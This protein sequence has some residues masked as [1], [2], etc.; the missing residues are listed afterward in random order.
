MKIIRNIIVA[1][2]LY[3]RIPMPIFTW[4]DEDME[5]S[6]AC[7]SLIGLV[8]GIVEFLAF[9]LIEIVNFNI[10]HEIPVFV[11]VIIYVLMPLII[12]GG[13]HVDGFMDFKDAINSYK[14]KDEKLAILKD[15]HIGAFS[16]ISLI[17]FGGIYVSS[18]YLLINN[19]AGADINSL[20]KNSF[21]IIACMSFIIARI[22]G[23][24]F[25]LRLTHA[26]KDGMLHSETKG[27]DKKSVIILLAQ[28]AVIGVV[29]L[30][31]NWLAFVCILASLLVF[32]IYYKNKC[33]KEF[34]GVTG[35]TT[36]YFITASEGII[37]LVTA[38]LTFI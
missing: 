31:L 38:I 27:A 34:G 30:V 25:S 12:T 16:V 5:Y 21:L 6:I 28:I 15:P 26:K 13:F 14:S 23:G 10:S 37:L 3:S 22:L 20:W 36:G 9:S 33:Y 19:M 8:I 11:R 29:V 24:I 2:A 17:I 35:D 18:A 1:F 4:K 7:L 32:S